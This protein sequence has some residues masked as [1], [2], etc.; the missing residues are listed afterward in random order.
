MKSH[1][2]VFSGRLMLCALGLLSISLAQAQSPV[3]K[4]EP[5]L[6]FQNTG[7]GSSGGLYMPD[8]R[9]MPA[10]TFRLQLAGQFFSAKDFLNPNDS[11]RFVETRASM[12]WGV[13]KNLE[14]FGTLSASSNHN[15]SEEPN[16][17]QSVGDFSIGVKVL[18]NTKPHAVFNF[19]GDVRAVFLNSVGGLGPYLK[20]TSVGLGL[21]ATTDFTQLK[22]SIPLIA[23]FRA[24][25]YLDNS[26]NLV[27]DTEKARYDSLTDPAFAYSDERRN[28]INRVER[29][30]YGINRVDQIK[31]GAGVEFPLKVGKNWQIR[32]LAEWK[33]GLPIN[34][35]KFDCVFVPSSTNPSESA[36][37]EDSCLNNE[38]FAAYPQT[39]SAA[40]RILPPTRGL[41]FFAGGD[42]GITG[43]DH[44][45][46]ELAATPPYMIHFGIAYTVDTRPEPP[47]I[48]V[49]EN[50]VRPEAVSAVPSGRVLGR[51]TDSENGQPVAHAVINFVGMKRTAL[52][53]DRD[54][55]FTV[56][57]AEPGP[58]NFEI[59]H[60]MYEAGQ[61]TAE[62]KDKTDVEVACKLKALPP[63]GSISGKILDAQTRT[64]AIAKVTITGP[65]SFTVESDAT[66]AFTI[67]EA[68]AGH[69]TARVDA[70]K[71]IA[72]STGFDVEVRKAAE[73]LLMVFAR[74]ESPSVVL[75][76]KELA[77][78]KQVRFEENKATIQ[79][80]SRGL[81]AE[82]AEVLLKNPNIRKVEIQGH[83]DSKG[84]TQR[85]T[86]LSQDRAEAVR[87]ALIERGVESSRLEAKGYGPSRPLVPN[88]TS[89][90]RARNRRVQIMILEKTK[91]ND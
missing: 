38:G 49:K 69:Y 9:T 52:Y 3:E 22:R 91:A 40:F 51:V 28:L 79:D 15:D 85:N 19:G 16:F 4:S 90:N 26:A 43:V 81:I 71:F 78:K 84:S 23:R 66:G 29:F 14:L 73:P 2:L 34:R 82:I 67:A 63:L 77:L 37:G 61:C 72:A 36:P 60:P 88:I 54:G 55:S 39:I 13:A 44:H 8:A 31:V 20:G 87:Q 74:P 89:R 83:T 50:A 56:E 53:A 10:G 47:R 42:L 70:D 45:V 35:Q 30:A 33:L 41:A 12:A 11:N 21:N 76:D 7:M 27:E 24:E 68:P 17:I 59:E 25:Y 58:W 65:A 1:C 18:K 48:I 5:G 86:Q 64:G 80:S 57:H 46:R 75:K 6:A 32:P 62:A